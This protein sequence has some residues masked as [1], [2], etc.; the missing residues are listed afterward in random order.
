MVNGR[1]VWSCNEGKCAVFLEWKCILGFWGVT[2]GNCLRR[3]SKHTADFEFCAF[4]SPE[5]G[6]EEEG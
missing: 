5:E 1:H 2:V 6:E 3:A 4:I